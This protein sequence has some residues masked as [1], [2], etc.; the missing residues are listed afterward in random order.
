MISKIL[1]GI[2]VGALCIYIIYSIYKLVVD[3]R[4]KRRKKR[5]DADKDK[6][7]Q[8]VKQDN[9]GALD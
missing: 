4:D 6:S 5:L 8:E 3:I 9:D 7:K 2:F 1:G